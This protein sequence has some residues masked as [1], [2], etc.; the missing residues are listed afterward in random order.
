MNAVETFEANRS[1]LLALGTKITGSSAAAQDL[2]NDAFLRWEKLEHAEI[3]NPRAM[4]AT[5][6]SRLAINEKNSARARREVLFEPRILW[7]M[8]LGEPGGEDLSDALSAA[9]QIVLSR[10]RPNER[11][12]FLLR[13]VFEFEYAEI[14]ATLEETES[15]C[16]Q[17]LRRAREKIC[18]GGTAQRTTP[19]EAELVLEQFLAATQSGEFEPLLSLMCEEPVLLRDA[20]NV[21]LPTPGPVIGRAAVVEFFKTLR[22]HSDRA[23][24]TIR[25]VG[26][27]YQ[28]AEWR[29]ANGGLAGAFIATIRDGRIETV[30]QISC[31]AKLGFLNRILRLEGEVP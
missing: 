24:F 6:V 28:L 8:D 13:E 9:L 10:L 17:L 23:F 3:R 27:G 25:S 14:A 1:F 7:G 18:A 20:G 29:E 2:V 16:R 26:E 11:A 31:P 4:L 12:V 19:R 22:G 15:N 30:R 21:G 5:I